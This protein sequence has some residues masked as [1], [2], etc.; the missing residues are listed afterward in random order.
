MFSASIWV[1]PDGNDASG[2]GSANQ[3]YK[4]ITYALNQVAANDS[5]LLKG[6]VYSENVNIIGMPDFVLTGASL[7]DTAF[8]VAPNNGPAI[9]IDAIEGN[10]TRAMVIENLYVTHASDTLDGAGIYAL[11][12][13][14]VIRNC[15]VAGNKLN[16]SN[17]VIPSGEQSFT[18]MTSVIPS[19][20]EESI[21]H[22]F[23][24]RFLVA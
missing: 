2:T 20:S 1:S 18:Q 14:L 7:V 24:F 9:L 4:T 16:D 8:I 3:P 21:R 19:A 10:V 23:Q 22:R 17:S 11:N 13:A 12:C 5:I 15:T 6:G